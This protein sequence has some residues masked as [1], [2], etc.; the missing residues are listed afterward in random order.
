MGNPP[1]DFLVLRDRGFDPAHIL[2]PTAG[3]PDSNLS[4]EVAALLR[5]EYGSEVTLLYVTDDSDE[6]ESFLREWTVEHNLVD[7]TLRVETGE[8]EAAIKQA[9]RDA[10]MVI[11]GATERGLLA[12]LV[13]RS[14]VLNVVDELECSVLLAERP[15]ARSL[16]ERLFG[17]RKEGFSKS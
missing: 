12:R 9:A 14:L 1:C 13:T 11:I 15:T 6:G 4:R 8:V 3:G 2:V 17:S 16:R 7:A 10:T 5:R